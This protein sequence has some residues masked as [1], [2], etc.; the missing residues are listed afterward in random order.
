[1]K[2]IERYP[3]VRGDRG[4]YR[5]VFNDTWFYIGSSVNLYRRQCVWVM[6]FNT[7]LWNPKANKNM[8]AIK[9][10]VT[11][12]RFDYLERTTEDIN[13]K[14]LE[15]QHIQRYFGHEYLLNIQP[16][17]QIPPI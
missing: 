2:N 9:P 11:K 10:L 5:I 6:I 4:V 1:M 13:E 7:A 16:T 15:T 14:E 12:I 3:F 8:K 17:A